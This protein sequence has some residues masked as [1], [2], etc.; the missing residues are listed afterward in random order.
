MTDPKKKTEA[1]KNSAKNLIVKP[2]T[3]A[4]AVRVVRRFHYS[5]K[6]VPNSQIHLGI[7]WNGRCEG[8]MQFGPPMD[9]RRSIGL[10]KDTRWN[11]F[12]ELNRMAFSDRLPRN[13]ESR[14]LAVALRMIKKHYPHIEWVLSFADATQCGDGTIYRAAGFALTAIKKNRTIIRLA[15]G[16]ITSAL[17]M[18]KRQHVVANKGRSAIPDGAER[19]KGFMLRYVYFLNPAARSRLTV[20]ELPYSEIEK[21]GAGMYKGLTRVKHSIDAAGVHPDQ[22]GA[23][24]THPLQPSKIKTRSKKGK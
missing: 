22:G 2:I 6:T 12:I 15:D 21:Q 17:T 3:A 20:P 8:A 7:F 18:T 14:A 10:V 13:A 11:G 24:P 9:K 4:S 23:E 19:I 1:G 16:T 5:G